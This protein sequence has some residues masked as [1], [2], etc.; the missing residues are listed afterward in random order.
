MGGGYANFVDTKVKKDSKPRSQER[1]PKQER[2]NREKKQQIEMMK[3]SF[4]I[5]MCAQRSEPAQVHRGD[6]HAI[7][8]IF[9][10]ASVS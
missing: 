1:T 9:H 2:Y 10:Y 5:R 8:N 3:K 7:R 6:L 4:L